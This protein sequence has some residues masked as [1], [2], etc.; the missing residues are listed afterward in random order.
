[1]LLVS[2]IWQY[3]LRCA[4]SMV[5]RCNVLQRNTLVNLSLIIFVWNCHLTQMLTLIFRLYYY[6]KERK[7]NS[8]FTDMSISD[9]FFFC[10]HWHSCKVW[11]WHN[12]YL[13]LICHLV[14][15]FQD[16]ADCNFLTFMTQFIFIVAGSAF[17]GSRGVWG[18]L[19]ALVCP[20]LPQIW[21]FS[22]NVNDLFLMLVV[23]MKKGNGH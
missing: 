23:R 11:S 21:G 19:Q 12:F 7:Y 22:L 16:F 18:K 17:A 9:T 5:L 1:M 4:L 14:V 20:F 2:L 15:S 3:W 10:L 8:L 6:Q 13:F